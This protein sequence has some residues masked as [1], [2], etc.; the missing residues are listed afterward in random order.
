MWN[1]CARANLHLKKK[2]KKAQVANELSNILLKSSHETKKPPPL[3]AVAQTT[4]DDIQLL[5]KDV[6]EFVISPVL[7][8]V[9]KTRANEEHVAILD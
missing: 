9:A 5:G 4:A 7:R 3:G 2:K 1:K 6:L 8:A